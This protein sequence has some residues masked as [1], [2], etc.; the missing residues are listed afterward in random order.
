[1][2]P[3][4]DMDPKET[5]W[6]GMYWIDLAQDRDKLRAVMNIVMTFQ[7]V[8]CR[9]FHECLINHQLIKNGCAPWSYWGMLHGVR[10]SLH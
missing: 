2:D 7:V 6:E 5:G 1:V 9:E 10:T 3:V 8:K 4:L